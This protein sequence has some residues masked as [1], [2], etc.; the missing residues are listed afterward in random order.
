MM[1]SGSHKTK[2]STDTMRNANYASATH[3]EMHGKTSLG[4]Y[5]SLF[6]LHDTVGNQTVGNLLSSNSRYGLLGLQSDPITTN[7]N[8]SQNAGQITATGGMTA[9]VHTGVMAGIVADRFLA[10]AVTR[11]RHVR[12]EG[13]KY[14]IDYY[15]Q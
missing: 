12:R 4:S 2:T 13:V 15:D 3:E 5:N 11:G 8:D 6:S 10:R 7:P 14:H 9:C 1:A